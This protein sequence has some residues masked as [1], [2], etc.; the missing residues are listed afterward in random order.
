MSNDLYGRVTDR[1]DFGHKQLVFALQRLQH[2][3]LYEYIFL[4][5]GVMLTVENKLKLCG[6]LYCH[7]LAMEKSKVWVV[8]GN[9]KSFE[10]ARIWKYM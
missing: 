7:K 10:I 5:S 1:V 6:P 2:T 8:T 9:K 3:H 4:Y